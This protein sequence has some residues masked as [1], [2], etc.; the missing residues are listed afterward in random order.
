MVTEENSAGV[1]AVFEVCHFPD[2]DAPYNSGRLKIFYPTT[3]DSEGAQELD[4]GGAPYPVVIFLVGKFV[5]M[6]RYQWLAERLVS[7]AKVM[8]VCCDAML[9]RNGSSLLAPSC[10]EDSVSSSKKTLETVIAKLHDHN[11]NGELAGMMNLNRILLGGHSSGGR[12]ALEHVVS[13]ERTEIAAVFSYGSHYAQSG[14]GSQE[15]FPREVISRPALLMVGNCDGVIESFS[16]V[17]GINW[18]SG[19][20]PVRRTFEECLK[21]NGTGVYIEFDGF[22]HFVMTDPVDQTTRSTAVDHAMTVSKHAAT[23]EL[24]HVI[25]L[26]VQEHGHCDEEAAKTLRDHLQSDN[27]LIKQFKIRP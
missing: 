8:C 16:F 5:E 14:D 10:L 18:A 24:G 15:I 3:V 7:D 26:F 13:E 9:L 12:V 11:E 19:A 1:L 4:S 25:T 17:Y 20:E 23:E 6:N 27:A 2:S 21:S 22:N